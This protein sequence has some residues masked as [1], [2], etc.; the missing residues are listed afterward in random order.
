MC[1]RNDSVILFYFL[2]SFQS[3]LCVFMPVYFTASQRY[4][5]VRHA[6]DSSG[7]TVF[8]C[9]ICSVSF[10]LLQYCSVLRPAVGVHGVSVCMWV[11]KPVHRLPLTCC[12][13]WLNN[14]MLTH[15]LY[16]EDYFSLSVHVHSSFC[17]LF[18]RFLLA[19]GKTTND[20]FPWLS[21]AF[22]LTMGKH[23]RAKQFPQILIVLHIQYFINISVLVTKQRI[24]SD[25]PKC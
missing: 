4:Y 10:E 1:G 16:S 3:Q 24:S 23:Q 7:C 20:L 2:T 8:G 11:L 6:D 22:D 13:G 17:L 9:V 21:K 19:L 25:V 12:V 5:S 14:H 18:F 15:V